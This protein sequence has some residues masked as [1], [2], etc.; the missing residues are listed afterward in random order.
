MTIE[1]PLT[2]GQVALVDDCD[3][4]V[5]EH[6]WYALRDGHTF[7]ANR[8]QR[9]HEIPEGEK[10]GVVHMHRAILDASDEFVVDHINRNGLDNRRSNLREVTVRENVWNSSVSRTSEF[11]GVNRR[12][13]G[14][15]VW[16]EVHVH[17]EGRQKYCGTYLS[18]KDAAVAADSVYEMILGYRPNGT[19][20]RKVVA[21]SKY[22]GTSRFAGV[23]DGRR[24]SS[25]S[26]RVRVPVGGKTQQFGT[27]DDELYAA[28]VSGEL[29]LE[30]CGTD[31]NCELIREYIKENYGYDI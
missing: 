29:Y 17:A 21:T 4:W 23:S 13:R 8:K 12:S 19:Y 6:K 26:W 11:L 14:D 5:L 15:R 10:R 24:K 18:E 25:D 30:Y 1:V 16:Y 2:Q 9:K 28:V 31:P 7:Y 22:G 3:A 27:Y 20:P